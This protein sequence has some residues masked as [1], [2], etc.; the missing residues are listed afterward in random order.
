MR[1]TAIFLL[2]SAAIAAP[3][4]AW[5]QDGQPA[6]SADDYVCAFSGQ[7]A[8]ED[9]DE[10]AEEATPSGPRPRLSATR[11]FAISTNRAPARNT[12]TRPR[13]PAASAGARQGAASPRR[14]SFSVSQPAGARNQRVNLSLNFPTGSAALTPQAQ[15]QAR[16]FGNALLMPQLATMRFRIEGHTDG[17]GNRAGN[18]AL[19]R[20]RAQSVAD[21]LIAMGVPRSRIDVQGYGPDRPLAGS[22]RNSPQNRRVEAVRVS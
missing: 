12:T 10:P 19:S 3:A 13:R 11:G 2:V 21:F 20:R 1:K 22:S 5:S 16:N 18:V 17:V 8:D 4:A 14:F 6:A 7:C 9:T 15:A